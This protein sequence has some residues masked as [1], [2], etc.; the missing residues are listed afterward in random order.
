MITAIDKEE[1]MS[2]S[3]TMKSAL[4][5][6]LKHLEAIGKSNSTRYTVN[7]DLTMLIA[8]LGE[9]KELAKILPVHI[10]GFFKS[11]PVNKI[12]DPPRER[13]PATVLQIKRITRQFL[14]WAQEQGYLDKVPLPKAEMMH[15]K[16]AEK[17]AKPKG[18][19][20]KKQAIKEAAP[21][22]NNTPQGVE[23]E[24][25]EVRAQTK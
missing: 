9:E 5:K 8:H 23:T 24:A 15:V 7:L 12:G 21:E 13:R 18:A 17:S 25:V 1:T 10:S 19:K 20:A 14:V 6:Y 16:A 3:I 4:E 22:A 2:K 11:E